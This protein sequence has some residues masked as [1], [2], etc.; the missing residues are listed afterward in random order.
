MNSGLTT[1][2]YV[3]LLQYSIYNFL[4]EPALGTSVCASVSPSGLSTLCVSVTFP[5]PVCGK[6]GE[7]DKDWRV[8][9]LN[10]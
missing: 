1:V 2:N 4:F 3:N 8:A 6:V 7:F 5:I 9:I 10:M